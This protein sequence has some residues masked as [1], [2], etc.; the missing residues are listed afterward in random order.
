VAPLARWLLR[1]LPFSGTR[2][3]RDS[4]SL[5]QLFAPPFDLSTG[6][7]KRNGQAQSWDKCSSFSFQGLKLQ[8]YL[9]R[10]FG[11]RQNYGPYLKQK[12]RKIRKK[13]GG[14]QMEFQST[15]N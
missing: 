10:A 15:G 8:R 2:F 12:A 1:S 4:T 5:L 11:K 3:Y 9:V 7:S 6:Q 14:G 13:G